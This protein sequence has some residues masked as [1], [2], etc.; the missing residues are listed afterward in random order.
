MMYLHLSSA[1]IYLSVFLTQ[2]FLAVHFRKQFYYMMYC[3]SSE[4]GDLRITDILSAHL[5]FVFLEKN[6]LCNISIP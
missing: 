4:Q 5:W 3:Q 1:S 2:M 6:C